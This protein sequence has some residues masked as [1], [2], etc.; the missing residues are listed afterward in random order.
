MLPV[1]A[2]LVSRGHQV[3][4]L[5]GGGFEGAVRAVGAEVV[6]LS[7]VADVYVPDRLTAPAVR[8]FVVGRLN[9]VSIHRRAAQTLAVE[10]ARCRP[11]VVVLDPMIG[12]AHRAASRAAGRPVMFSTTFASTSAASEV[13][14]RRYG[15]WW[16]AGVQRFR[17]FVRRHRRPLLAHALPELQPAAHLLDRRTHLL[18]PLVRPAIEVS[19]GTGPPRLLVSFGTVFARGRAVFRDVVEAVGGS[20][21]EVLLATGQTDP[22]ALGPLPSNVTARRWV[23]QQAALANSDVFLTHA[24]MNSAM[25]AL[26]A[27]VPMLFLPRSREQRF[28]ADRLSVLGVGRPL[29]RGR[30]FETV[31]AV[32]RD[33]RVL[34]AVE[35]WRLRLVASPGARWAADVLEAEAAQGAG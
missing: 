35:A 2:E 33:R 14:V 6:G 29:D 7:A 18:G 12:W 26:V 24:G 4:A 11:E 9:R 31:T 19:R 16:A 1:M 17:P 25:E 34:A 27:G 21:W 28:I 8:R 32:A 15:P 3:R 10:L 22:D 23:D 13:L 20:A 5:V 30:I